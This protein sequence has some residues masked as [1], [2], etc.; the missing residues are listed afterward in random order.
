MCKEKLAHGLLRLRAHW[1]VRNGEDWRASTY[2]V[3]S[4]RPVVYAV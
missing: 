2:N 1:C 4:G 3:N